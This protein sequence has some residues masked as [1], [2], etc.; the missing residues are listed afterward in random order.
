MKLKFI[1]DAFYNG[2]L[3]YEKGSIHEVCNELGEA[4]R[5]LSRH[6]AVE[7]LQ[8]EIVDLSSE[9]PEDIEESV[10]EAEEIFEEEAPPIKS[11]SKSKSKSK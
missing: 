4:Q 5:W 2:A 6:V 9:F 11:K 10:N 8:E 1:A 3:K 7:V